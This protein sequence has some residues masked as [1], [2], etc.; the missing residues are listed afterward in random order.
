L[1]F[2]TLF[3]EGLGEAYDGDIAFASAIES[4]GGG[5]NDPHFIALGG[6]P[7]GSFPPTCLV[8]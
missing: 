2:L 3:R 7:C 6:K 1:V 5:Q 4:F 8:L